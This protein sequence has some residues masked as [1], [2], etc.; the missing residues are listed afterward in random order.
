MQRKT[1]ELLGPRASLTVQSLDCDIRNV[2]SNR[3]SREN[4]SGDE[5]NIN[6][7]YSLPAATAILIFADQ[8][9]FA[10]LAAPMLERFV[11]FPPFR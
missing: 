6:A 4:E 7:Y 10:H 9:V 1:R 2:A 11:T 3:R 8:I 5:H